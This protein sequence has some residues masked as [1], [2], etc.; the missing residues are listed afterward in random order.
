MNGGGPGGLSGG[1]CLP[2]S[3]SE[4]FP[5]PQQK[6]PKDAYGTLGLWTH[7]LW[8]YSTEQSGRLFRIVTFSHHKGKV[9]DPH[10]VHGNGKHD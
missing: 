2:A 3:G 6:K 10:F 5:L 1:D 4:L 7:G 8:L 9:Q